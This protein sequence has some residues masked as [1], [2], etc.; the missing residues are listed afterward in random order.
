M[1]GHTN[2]ASTVQPIQV[3]SFIVAKGW[4]IPKIFTD[5][6]S[7]DGIPSHIPD[8]EDYCRMCLSRNVRCTYKPMSNWSAELIDITQPDHPNPDNNANNSNRD[9]RQTKPYLLTGVTRTFLVR[10]DIWQSQAHK[11][12]TSSCATSY[13]RR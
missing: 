7:D 4:G 8:L 6:D 2:L 10:E 9:N 11:I 12:K 3:L 13:N 5:S 1:T